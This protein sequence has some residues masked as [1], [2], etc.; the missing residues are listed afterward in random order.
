MSPLQARLFEPTIALHVLAAG[1]ALALG[2]W[3][4]A[5]RKGSRAH[6]LAGLASVAAMVATAASSFLIDA[7][8]LA[9]HTPLGA[10]G[11]IHLLSAFTLWMLVRAVLAARRRDIVQHRRAMTGSYVGL[12]IAGA[13]T[14]APG[15]TL[16]AWLAALAA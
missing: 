14:L 13:F 10:F 3:L 11:P 4:L 16:G 8:I 7:R 9:L 15:R 2:A 5:S 12:A 1:I 6:R